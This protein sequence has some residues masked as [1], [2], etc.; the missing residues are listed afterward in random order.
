MDIV[1]FFKTMVDKAN[2]KGAFNFDESFALSECFQNLFGRT[3]D[4]QILNDSI[5]LVISALHKGQEH[6]SFSLEQSSQI[7]SSLQNVIKN[8]LNLGSQNQTP[9]TNL[10]ETSQTS[11]PPIVDNISDL[12][13]PLPLV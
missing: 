4:T 13:Q 11:D 9:E 12:V 8:G 3:Q 7:H 1:R 5:K 6:G 10:P 2:L